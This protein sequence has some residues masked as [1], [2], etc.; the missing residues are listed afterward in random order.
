MWL[1]WQ[2]YLSLSTNVVS[3][4]EALFSPPTLCFAVAK[5]LSWAVLSWLLWQALPSATLSL[6]MYPTSC[7][8]EV[9]GGTMNALSLSCGKVFNP[10]TLDLYQWVEQ[11]SR[12][13][14]I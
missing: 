7:L 8:R 1:P 11:R 6:D 14:H 2:A 13:M 3:A 9:P 5:A 12:I 4:R 10:Q